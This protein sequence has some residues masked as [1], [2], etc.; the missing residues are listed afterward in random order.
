M[1]WQTSMLLV[2]FDEGVVEKPAEVSFERFV[3]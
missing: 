1:E 3:S 2:G